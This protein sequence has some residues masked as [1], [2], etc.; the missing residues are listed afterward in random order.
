MNAARVRDNPI[1]SACRQS[2]RRKARRTAGFFLRQP[3]IPV[4]QAAPARSDGLRKRARGRVKAALAGSGGNVKGVAR[5]TGIAEST[6]RR[7]KAEQLGTLKTVDPDVF[8]ANTRRDE[9]T[10]CLIWT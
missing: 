8:A 3:G 6:V 9:T 5:E 7:W 4:G 2:R 10:G 1:P